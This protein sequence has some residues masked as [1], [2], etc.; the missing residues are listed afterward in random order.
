M[1][2][3]M[4]L[5]LNGALAGYGFDSRKTYTPSDPSSAEASSEFSAAASRLLA[6]GEVSGHLKGR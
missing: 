1:G 6:F 3:P 5:L 4:K 2:Q